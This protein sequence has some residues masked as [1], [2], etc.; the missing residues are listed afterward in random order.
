[1]S[2]KLHVDATL[3]AAHR[4]A[5]IQTENEQL[6]SKLAEHELLFAIALE[7]DR[8]LQEILAGIGKL[9]PGV[10]ATASGIVDAVANV[11]LK[12]DAHEDAS[13]PAF[14][15]IVKLCGL[16]KTWE[17]PGQVIR[18]VGDA[19]A[20]RDARIAQLEAQQRAPHPP[21]LA[22]TFVGDVCRDCGLVAPRHVD[23]VRQ[24]SAATDAEP[25][26]N[27]VEL[28]GRYLLD[29]LYAYARDRLDPNRDREP[30]VVCACSPKYRELAPGVH[31]AYCPLAGRPT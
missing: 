11:V 16:A 5:E 25:P 30:P 23:G 22:H 8:T 14:D 28:S 15:E 4:M 17:Y 18:D 26:P 19:L 2:D 27:L 12:L 13:T 20:R 9:L 24:L 10:E 29:S 3:V 21:C 7:N 1:M 31:A 6:R